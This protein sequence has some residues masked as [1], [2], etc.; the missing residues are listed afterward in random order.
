MSGPVAP[1]P[2]GA[3]GAKT[4][5]LLLTLFQDVY[6]QEIGAEEDVHRTLPF[7]ATA[8]GFLIAA[9]NYAVG[10]LPNLDALTR[11][12]P[13]A[14]GGLL[15][16]HSLARSWPVLLAMLLLVLAAALGLGVLGFLAAATKR[17]SYERAGP[18]PAQLRR[19]EELQLYHAALGLPDTA[20]D[21]AVSLD[22]RQQLLDNF[23]VVIPHNRKL[24]LQ[25]YQYRARAVSCLLLSLFFAL[26]ATILVLVA[27]KT[28][29]LLRV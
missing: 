7:F 22:L 17:L 13:W 2:A 11:T 6:R 27:G 23:A 14:E 18:E 21:D 16:H 9:I 4:G 12:Y 1:A 8:L 26:L 29:L 19:A 25:R 5:A 3:L 28:G 15:N 10:Q 24:T 20:L